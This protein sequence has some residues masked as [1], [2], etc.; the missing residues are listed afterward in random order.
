MLKIGCGGIEEHAIL[1][2][3]WLLG[4]DL[5]AYL[6]LGHGLPEGLNAAY[7]LVRFNQ[8]YSSSISDQLLL[9]SAY[10]GKF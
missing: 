1:L 4:M 2:T 3:C 10:N 7:V 6:V 5:T 9:I 8:N